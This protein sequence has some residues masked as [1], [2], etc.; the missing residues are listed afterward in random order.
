MGS[1]APH[2]AGVRGGDP[3][4]RSPRVKPASHTAT[5]A[6]VPS[7]ARW[8]SDVARPATRAADWVT[9]AK[10]RLNLLV[11]VTTAAGLYLASPDGVAMPVLFHTLMGTALVAGG[12]A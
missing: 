1:E 12:A 2:R 6:A 10:P 8:D 4:A 11:L 7:T 3:A 9:L 5:A